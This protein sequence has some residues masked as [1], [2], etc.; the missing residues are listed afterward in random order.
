MFFMTALILVFKALL[1]FY[2]LVL[3]N[4]AKCNG[5]PLEC[6][7]YYSLSAC[8]FSSYGKFSPEHAMCLQV[9]A[10]RFDLGYL[11]FL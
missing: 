2:P 11:C 9:L 7:H 6:I 5:P 3:L 10:P 8:Q 1:H 4:P